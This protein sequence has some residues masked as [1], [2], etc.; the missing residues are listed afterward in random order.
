M[1]KSLLF[2]AA[3]STLFTTTLFAAPVACQMGTYYTTGQSC[4]T[5]NQVTIKN[6]GNNQ[7]AISS[8]DYHTNPVTGYASIVIYTPSYTGGNCT[9]NS[10]ALQYGLAPQKG[11]AS[12]NTQDIMSKEDQ[13]IDTWYCDPNTHRYY[14]A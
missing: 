12:E 8:F 14:P 1:K 3:S 2:L 10:A 11:P 7:G 13:F 4:S 9:S 5:S 6:N